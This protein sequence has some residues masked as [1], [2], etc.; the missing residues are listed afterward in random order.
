MTTIKPLPTRFYRLQC[1]HAPAGVNTKPFGHREEDKFWRCGGTA[2]RTGE[3][4]FHHCSR[5]RDQQKA[6]WKAVGKAMGW[7]VG[8]W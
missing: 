6:L 8:R 2:T 5:W 3:H 1:G 4:L 7:K